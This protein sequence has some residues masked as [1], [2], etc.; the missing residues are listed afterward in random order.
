MWSA[1]SDWDFGRWQV[2]SSIVQNVH[3]GNK[4]YTLC[5]NTPERSSVS[6]DIRDGE[7]L[8]SL[9]QAQL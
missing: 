1:V 6:S 5:S 7:G 4:M 3:Q 8:S 2:Q 9:A